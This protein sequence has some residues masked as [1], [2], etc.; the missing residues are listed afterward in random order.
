[1]WQ[2]QIF[3]ASV[4]GRPHKIPSGWDVICDRIAH[5]PRVVLEGS[6]TFLYR[7]KGAPDV[8]P[9]SLGVYF[10][11]RKHLAEKMIVRHG[12]QALIGTQSFRALEPDEKIYLGNMPAGRT[13]GDTH[14]GEAAM[15]LKNGRG[16]VGLP[17]QL[18]AE[19]NRKTEAAEPEGDS[20]NSL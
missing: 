7:A 19:Y 9:A 18:P 13:K 6:D 20:G 14:W 11:M 17:V 1:M 3:E 10:A 5:F 4:E 2:K 15:P 12:K 16:A 8:E